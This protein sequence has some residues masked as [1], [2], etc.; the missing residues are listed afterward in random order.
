MPWFSIWILKLGPLNDGGGGGV[1]NVSK[2]ILKTYGLTFSS[3]IHSVCFS[4]TDI[5]NGWYNLN[6]TSYPLGFLFKATLTAIYCVLFPKS[7]K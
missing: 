3:T 5:G 4:C 1:I 7:N 6:N 2:L